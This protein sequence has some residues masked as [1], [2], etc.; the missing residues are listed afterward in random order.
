MT[1]VCGADNMVTLYIWLV[2]N[3]YKSPHLDT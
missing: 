3:T 1:E 2:A